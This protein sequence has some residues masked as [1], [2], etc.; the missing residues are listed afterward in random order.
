MYPPPTTQTT[1]FTISTPLTVQQM[2][3]AVHG[4]RSLHHGAKRTYLALCRQFPGHGIP[5]HIVQDLV[6]ECPICQKDRL[7]MHT[8]PNNEIHETIFHRPRS[9][10]IN[11][12]TVT[13]HDEDG[14]VGLLHAVEL[15]TKF[16]QAY[17]IREYTATTVRLNTSCHLLALA[18]KVEKQLQSSFSNQGAIE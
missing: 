14:Y 11:H 8:I 13:P 5:L 17:P 10:G 3:D 12:V 7:P 16:P 4:G 9:I 1:L 6:S 15:D 2:F 18:A